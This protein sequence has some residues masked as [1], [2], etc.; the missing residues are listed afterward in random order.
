[1]D[2]NNELFLAYL[3]L[4]FH[5][6]LQEGFADK[7]RSPYN[8]T[9]SKALAHRRYPGP[10]HMA[11]WWYLAHMPEG[12]TLADALKETTSKSAGYRTLEK[13]SAQIGAYID[14]IEAMEPSL[15]RD[16]CTG[17][18]ADEAQTSFM[19]GLTGASGSKATEAGT[20]A[21]YAR[22]REARE[23]DIIE[24]EGPTFSVSIFGFGGPPRVIAAMF[25]AMVLVLAVALAQYTWTELGSSRTAASAPGPGL[26]D[27]GL[28]N[29][30]LVAFPREGDDPATDPFT[31]D[32]IGFSVIADQDDEAPVL[33]LQ[34]DASANLTQDGHEGGIVPIRIIF[35][36]PPASATAVEENPGLPPIEL[37]ANVEVFQRKPG[38]PPQTVYALE[39]DRDVERIWDLPTKKGWWVS[40]VVEN[41]GPIQPWK[42][43]ANMKV[44]WAHG[45]TVAEAGTELG[46]RTYLLPCGLSELKIE[47][48]LH[49]RNAPLMD[50]A[51]R[52]INVSVDKKCA[53]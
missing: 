43:G 22:L 8:F 32:D 53:T 46:I 47:A 37:S 49:M 14:G 51:I 23:P 39:A 50:S 1:M 34:V 41:S 19:M 24:P 2:K 5:S 11:V 27:P 12:S 10:K 6:T 9:D 42:F 17:L 26:Y 36:A 20:D 28:G 7:R 18:R 48:S 16:L 31:V 13:T 29:V 40:P 21:I 33:N 44:G 25:I 38:D 30:A 15:M 52:R 35:H 4:E 45:D 3:R